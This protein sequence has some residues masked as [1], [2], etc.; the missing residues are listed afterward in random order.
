MS[1]DVDV[2][3]R[4]YLET[5]ERSAPPITIAELQQSG[6]QGGWQQSEPQV[7]DLQR[8]V[9]SPASTPPKRR[10]LVALAAAA[11]SLSVAGIVA[12]EGSSG[13]VVTDA[14]SSPTVAEPVV[15]AVPV[16]PLVPVEPDSLHWPL[17]FHD[18]ALSGI[19][20][21]STMSAVVAGGPGFVAVG[22]GSEGNAPVWTS[23]DG[24]S[25]SPVAH[26][27]AVFRGGMSDVTVGG[28]GLVA[29]GDDSTCTDHEVA[30]REDPDTV[31]VDGN[32]VVWTS[33]DGLTWS[34]VPHDEA[35]FGGDGPQSMSAVTVGGPGLVAVGRSDK[36]FEGQPNVDGTP[37]EGD[38]VVWTSVDGLTWSRVPHD[39][40]VF[41]GVETQE[42]LDAT[43]GGPGLVAVGRDG[44]GGYWGNPILA[45]GGQHAAVWVSADGLT[46][47]RVPHDEDA[48][49]GRTTTMHSVTAGGPGLVAVGREVFRARG[50]MDLG[51]WAHLVTSHSRKQIRDERRD[52]GCDHR[53]PRTRSSR[54][55]RR[56]GRC[57]DLARRPH[58]VSCSHRRTGARALPRLDVGRDRHKRTPDRRRFPHPEQ[59]LP[60]SGS[61]MD[62]SE[63][64]TIRRQAETDGTC[65]GA[66]TIQG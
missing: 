9:E 54:D 66:R 41:G 35:V 40:E 11:A 59:R 12:V 63:A 38:A 43:A 57:V 44:A 14:V 16:T 2:Q 10:I 18:Q 8:P 50:R 58:L 23:I 33:V 22:G 52:G 3:L 21:D 19:A 30:G 51:R 62:E 36:R 4:S 46:W 64:V 34:R 5:I 39:E 61:S 45:R 49:G 13:K 42:M 28:P 31:C 60:L 48:F 65:R 37:N 24:L 29:V 53:S 25:W 17:V 32:A 15:T 26:D 20:P 56:R 55:K 7:V 47:T 1:T 6:G 27:E